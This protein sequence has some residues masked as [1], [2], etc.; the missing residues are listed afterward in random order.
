ML[1]IRTED[2][3]FPLGILHMLTEDLL[4][5]IC[6]RQCTPKSLQPLLAFLPNRL[7]L[8]GPHPPLKFLQIFFIRENRQY[9]LGRIQDPP[10]N[11]L[12]QGH[13]RGD[14]SLK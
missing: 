14:I 7:I 3:I 1:I 5:P 4:K 10:H 13:L 6:L 9:I 8:H 12:T 2:N 11:R